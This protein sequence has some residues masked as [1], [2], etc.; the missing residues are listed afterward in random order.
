MIIKN[1]IDKDGFHR[2][3]IF[4]SNNKQK[5]FVQVIDVDEYEGVLTGGNG[6]FSK[7]NK[8]YMRYNN[9]GLDDKGNPSQ[10]SELY[11][12]FNIDDLSYHTIMKQVYPIIVKRKRFI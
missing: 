11:D 9:Y 10:I 3:V 1:K 6:I 12:E 2:E 4:L 8:F 5:E 7:D